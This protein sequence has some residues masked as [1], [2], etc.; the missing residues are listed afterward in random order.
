M[1]IITR[2]EAFR[3][4]AKT[5]A[6][7]RSS[8]SHTVFRMVIERK[9]EVSSSS[10]KKS[11]IVKVGHLNLVDLAGSENATKHGNEE[12]FQEGKNINLSLLHLKE[13]I[14]K[15]SKRE[16]VLSFR[17]SKLTR[18][19]GKSLSGNAK[20]AVICNISPSPLQLEQSV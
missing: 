16:K 9:D 14:M 12:R 11:T 8:R 2:G 4:V 1:D 17:N 13:V 3:K 18:I 19:L 5:F 7:D 10:S 15:L 6:N 20:I